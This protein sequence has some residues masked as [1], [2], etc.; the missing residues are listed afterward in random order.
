MIEMSRIIFT[1]RDAAT[2][3]QRGCGGDAEVA[4]LREFPLL[5]LRH[6]ELERKGL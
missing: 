1:L 2:W 6:S 4:L 5:K 3:Y